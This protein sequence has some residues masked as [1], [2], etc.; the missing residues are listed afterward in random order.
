MVAGCESEKKSRIRDKASR[1][2]VATHGGLP[3]NHSLF[4]NREL[5]RYPVTCRPG[6]GDSV[7]AASF[8]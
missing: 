4:A 6:T 2:A 5:T 8:S 3:E 7:R 1:K